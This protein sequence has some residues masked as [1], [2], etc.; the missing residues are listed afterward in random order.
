MPAR[1]IRCRAIEQLFDK[2]VDLAG[3]SGSDQR[4][5]NALASALEFLAFDQFDS[6]SG[7]FGAGTSLGDVAVK[8]GFGVEFGDGEVEYDFVEVACPE[9]ATRLKAFCA[10][11]CRF[12]IQNRCQ[13]LSFAFTCRLGPI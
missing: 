7:S 5:A 9:L 1:S 13:K 6:R 8:F 4:I 11:P 3:D 10:L 12:A 2:F